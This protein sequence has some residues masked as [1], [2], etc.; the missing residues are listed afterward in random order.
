MELRVLR[1]FLAVAREESVSAAAE[2]LHI[3]QPTLSRQI[4]DLEDELG[5]K[6]FV[7]GAKSRRLVLTDEGRLLRK[8][9]QEI[10]ELADRAKGEI[11]SGESEISGDI[12]IGAGETDAMRLLAAAL[13]ELRESYPEL[14]VHLYSGNA[15]AI[16][17][18]LERGLID[19]GVII[20]THDLS[21]YDSLK[22][23]VKDRWGVLA[24]LNSEA[25][26]LSGISPENIVGI[27]L[28]VSAQASENGE[29]S[30]WLKGHTLKTIATYNLVHN[31]SL[32]VEEGCGCA[33]TLEN[34]VFNPEQRGLCF[35]PLV[36]EFTSE[37]T[38]VW[39]RCSVLSRAA[40]IFL[41]KIQSMV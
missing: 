17:E 16:I 10:V 9:A 28:F 31:A 20:G 24:P 26:R 40:E 34:L 39:K 19:F 1:Y 37:I 35:R 41:K 8:R 21:K 25:A 22:L 11:M 18:R 13:R 29:L 4:M 6:L 33:L 38:L 32:F 30:S 36:P 12:Y 5:A 3:T 7:R 15:H 23:P 2:F 14:K 27:P